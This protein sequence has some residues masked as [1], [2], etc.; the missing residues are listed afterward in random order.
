V[1]LRGLGLLLAL[2][3]LTGCA[4]TAYY[5]QSISGH[6][7]LLQAAGRLTTGWPTPQ[8]PPICA[9]GCSWRSRCGVLR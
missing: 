2:L 8:R 4:D 5:W 1:L 3:W 6:A 9:S 7:R